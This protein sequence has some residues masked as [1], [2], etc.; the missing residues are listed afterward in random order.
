MSFL[1][2]RDALYSLF[3]TSNNGKK[4]YEKNAVGWLDYGTLVL[5]KNSAFEQLF[6]HGKCS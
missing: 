5:L 6:I 4:L 1:F 3:I 2:C